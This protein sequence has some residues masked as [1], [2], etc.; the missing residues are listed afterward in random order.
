MQFVLIRTY[1][2]GVHFGYLKSRKEKEVELVN[3]QRVWYWNGACSLSQMA[4]DGVSKPEDCKFS[5]V[6]PNIILTEAIE[7][8]TVTEKARKNLQGVTVWKK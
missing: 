8:I 1:S 6:V 2:A 4:V 7:I 5:V 3:A